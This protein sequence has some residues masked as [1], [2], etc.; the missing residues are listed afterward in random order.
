M[1]EEIASSNFSIDEH[2]LF[3]DRLRHETAILKSWFDDGRLALAGDRTVGLEVEAWLIDENHLPTP[4]NDD[5][6]AETRDPDIVAELSRF[7]F[8]INAPVRTLG[9]GLL[10]ATLDDLNKVWNTC[11]S[12]ADRLAITPVAIGI[13]PTVRDEMLQP[14][15]MSQ[16]NRYQ[17][18]NQELLIRRNGEDIHINIKGD[19]SLDYRCDHIMLEAACTSLQA[20]LCVGQ[21]EAAR[22]YNAAVLAAGPLIAATANSPFLYGKSLWT[23]TRIPAFE[24]ATATE[25]FRDAAGRDV[26]RVTLGTGYV[27]NSLLELFLENLAY[28]GLLPSLREDD[29]KLPHLRLQNGTIWRWV[30]PI[31]GFDGAGTPHL[32]LEHRVMPAGPSLIDMVANLA[33]C[34]G[35]VLA[36]GNAETPPETQTPFTDAQENLYACAQRGLDAMVRWAGRSVPVQTLLLEHLLPM[37]RNALAEAGLGADELDSYFDGV[38]IPRLQ[39]GQTGAA[40]Q[41]RAFLNCNRNFQA[42]TE[43]Y[44]AR[45][46]TGAPVH[47]WPL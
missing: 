31:L 2:R 5:F 28:P 39:T 11:Q 40:W 22:L 43:R 9:A 21:G 3:R 14:S 47:E 7:N 10:P 4:R 25:L 16:S 37:S 46:K 36:L 41:R 45:Q 12:A 42:L 34:H 13:L 38:L 20:H 8:E 32:R 44:V 15:W 1:G 30:R 27:R 35:L 17:A 18:L 26:H 19:E 6:F 33:F 29:G 24:Q 23:E